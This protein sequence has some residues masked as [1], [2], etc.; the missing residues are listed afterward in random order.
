MPVDL[1]VDEAKPDDFDALL[2]PGGVMN[3]DHLRTNPKA[4]HFAREFFDAHRPIAAISTGTG[5]WWKPWV[6]LDGESLWKPNFSVWL[7]GWVA[8]PS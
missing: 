3:P 7:P 6:I 2:L 4:V 8:D 5:C 1:T